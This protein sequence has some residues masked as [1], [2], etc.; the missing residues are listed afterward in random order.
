[1]ADDSR[2]EAV[3]VI[4]SNEHR[5]WWG[6]DSCGYR[7]KLAN[8]G[9]YGRDDAI[10]ICISARGGREHNHNPTEVPLLLRDAAA[11][12]PDDRAEWERRRRHWDEEQRKSELRAFGIED[13]RIS[14]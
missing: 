6:P 10:N 12:W 9:R 5:C 7:A 11:F 8:A 3:Y 2:D 1:M 4:W 14:S 13:L